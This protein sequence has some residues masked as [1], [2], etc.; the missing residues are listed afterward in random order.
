MPDSPAEPLGNV[1]SR[2]A[3]IKVAIIEDRRDI[4]EG[5]AVVINRTA[6]YQCTNSYGSMEQALECIGDDLPHAVLVD[7]G[8]PGMSGIEGIQI[9]KSRHHSL[10][11]SCRPC[12]TTTSASLMPYALEH[13]GI[14]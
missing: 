1:A 8:L 7:I 9:L 3:T 10:L 14:L 13:A 5:L 12:I 4:R 2:P 11:Q 6:G